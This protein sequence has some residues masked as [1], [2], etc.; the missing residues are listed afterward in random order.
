MRSF[1]LIGIYGQ[2]IRTVQLSHVDILIASGYNITTSPSGIIISLNIFLELL[3]CL[4]GG[5]RFLCQLIH[6]FFY[7]DIQ[8]II[9][10]IISKFEIVR[11]CLT[12]I[13]TE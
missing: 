13:R 12:A 3:I 8:F 5:K 10:Y 1:C 4:S 7:L 2:N 9:L 6:N 11:A